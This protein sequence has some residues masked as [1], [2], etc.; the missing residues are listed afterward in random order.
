M[1]FEAGNLDF[2][3]NDSRRPEHAHNVGFLGLAQSDNEVSRVLSQIAGRSRN[4]K[5]LAV[6]P[7]ENFNLGADRALV[8]SQPFERKP[9]PV[10][11][12]AAFV[13]Q[14]H[15]RAVILGDQQI[16]GAVAVVV[17]GNDRSR[18]FQLNLVQANVGW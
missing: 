15:R 10:V 2:V 14:Q 1:L 6:R 5:L 16:G 13:A 18:I 7:G 8:V 11:L 3:L 12:V 9:Q 4:F 17:A